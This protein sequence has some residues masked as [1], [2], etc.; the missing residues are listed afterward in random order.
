MKIGVR[1]K[2]AELLRG[3]GTSDFSHRVQWEDCLL[4][5]W[6]SVMQ[7]DLAAVPSCLWACTEAVPSARHYLLLSLQGFVSS[8]LAFVA[9]AASPPPPKAPLTLPQPL[10]TSRGSAWWA[11]WLLHCCLHSVQHNA[12]LTVLIR[13]LLN[14]CCVRATVHHFL[15]T[16]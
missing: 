12:Y 6:G 14:R 16:F 10:P 1:N 3:T 9:G 11:C 7:P 4:V 8:L 13:C 5:P 2:W 15:S